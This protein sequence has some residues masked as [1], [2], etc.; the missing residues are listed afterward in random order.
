MIWRLKKKEN[1]I[2]F[3]LTLVCPKL[4]WWFCKTLNQIG[5][6]L[7]TSHGSKLDL[8]APSHYNE[9]KK[10]TWNE[11]EWIAKSQYTQKS[12]RTDSRGLDRTTDSA[13]R[14]VLHI[15]QGYVGTLC[16][17]AMG[18]LAVWYGNVQSMQ[19]VDQSLPCC[20]RT[21][22]SHCVHWAYHLCTGCSLVYAE[23]FYACTIFRWRELQCTLTY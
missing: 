22:R 11:R 5:V 8:K 14:L 21:K 12:R 23:K 16:K 4:R 3:F 1:K 7:F 18:M 6:A 17:D 10:W 13:L 9:L 2:W 20:G 19:M 15:P